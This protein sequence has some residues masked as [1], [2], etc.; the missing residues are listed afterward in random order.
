MQDIHRLPK[1]VVQNCHIRKVVLHAQKKISDLC[2]ILQVDFKL[3]I[4]AFEQDLEIK[5]L[6]L[7]AV[8]QRL[9]LSQLPSLAV[10]PCPLVKAISFCEPFPQ[11]PTMANVLADK[12]S[13]IQR[14][15]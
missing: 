10:H 2:P 13:F 1:I 8:Y 11:A 3:F 12:R 9:H 4:E 15:M 5:T 6:V 7:P 14:Q